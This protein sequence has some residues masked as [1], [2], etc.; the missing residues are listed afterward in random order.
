MA[1]IEQ[2]VGI[3]GDSAAAPAAKAGARR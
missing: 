1:V 2:A 3:D